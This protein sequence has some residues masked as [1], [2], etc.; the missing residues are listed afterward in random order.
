VSSRPSARYNDPGFLYNQRKLLKYFAIASILM[1]IGVLA[2][3]YVDW[4][5][6]WKRDQLAEMKWEARKLELENMILEARTYQARKEFSQKEAAANEK[7]ESRRD[8]LKEIQKELTELRGAFY[9]ADYDYKAQKQFTGK[10]IYEREHAHADEREKYEQQL[11]AERDKEARLKELVN[12]ANERL[13]DKV[14]EEKSLRVELDAIV[15]EMRQNPELKKMQLVAAAR[16]KKRGYNPLRDVPLLDFLAPPTKVE[17]VVLE[18]LVDN[19]EFALPKKVDRCGTCHVGVMRLGFEAT[20]WPLEALEMEAGQQKSDLLEQ[21]VYE[22]VFTLL[23]SVWPKTPNDSEFKYENDLLRTLA[24]HHETLNMLFVGYDPE[25]GTIPTWEKGPRKGRKIWKR[26]RFSEKSGRWLSGIPKGKTINDYPETGTSLLEYYYGLLQRMEKH[27]RSH[28]FLKDM[29][30]ST[31]PH[32]YEKVGCTVCHNGR[33]WSTDFG[34][35][36]HVPDRNGIDNWMTVARAEEQHLHLPES[37]DLTLDEA[38]LIGAFNAYEQEAWDGGDELKKKLEDAVAAAE[39]AVKAAEG[40]EGANA[41]QAKAAAAKAR[42]DL[43][44]FEANLKSARAKAADLRVGWVTDDEKGHRWHDDLDW[45]H[46]KLHH[47]DWPQLPKMLVQ[48]SCLKCHKEGLYRTAETEYETVHIG[49]PK[50]NV[51]STKSIRPHFKEYNDDPEGDYSGRMFVPKQEEPYRPEALEAGMDAFLRF[52]CYG[53]HKLDPTVYTFMEHQRDKVGPQ[54]NDITSKT[55]KAWTRKWVRNPKDYRPGTRMPRFFGLSNNS[56]DFKYRFADG[57]GNTVEVDAEA[58]NNA[59]IYSIVEWMFAESEKHGTFEAPAVDLSKGDKKRGERILVAFGG[60]EDRAPKACVA[61]HDVPI[62]T[63]E[64]AYKA[65]ELRKW[66]NPATDAKVGWGYRMSRR[67]G[68]DL[69]GLG[70]KLKPEWLVAWLKD[71]RS[72]WHDT[73]MPDLRLTDQE[74][75][76]V[77]A[78]LLSLRHEKF[79]ALE[80]V[81]ADMALV[82][83]IAQELKVGEQ[84]EPTDVALGIV[85]R[86]SDRERVLYVGG[87]LFKN[88]GCFGC[89]SVN[90][91]AT[92]SPI[93]TELTSWGSKLIDRLAFNHVPMEKTRFDFAYTKMMNPRVFDLG[94]AAA[95]SPFERLQMP[96]FNFTSEEAKSIATFLVGLVE[97]PIPE[98]ALF[99]ADARKQQ[100]IDG[101]HLVRRFNCQGCHVIEGEGGDVWPAIAE[102]KWRP[103]DLLGQGIKTN[104]AWLFHFMRDPS[105]VGEVPGIPDSDRVR[106]WHAIRMPTF[107][108]TDDESRTIVRYFAALSKA[109]NDFESVEPDSLVGPGAKFAKS[110]VREIKDLNDPEGKK[111]LRYDVDN[112]LRETEILFAAL[113]CKKCHS[114][115]AELETAAPNFRHTRAGRLRPEWIRTWL[116]NPSKLQPGT[117]MPTFFASEKGPKTDFKAFHGGSP[118]D[119]IR[120]LRDYIR[121]HYD[122]TK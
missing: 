92:T 101:R 121:W 95:E 6:P 11:A 26:Y 119:Q 122:D 1:M 83:R 118:D 109:P 111:K 9:A 62:T 61:C 91:Y 54:L 42:R 46:R 34:F 93:G 7:F 68:P 106:P 97:D 53:C 117:A 45:T 28:P 86:M 99:K 87:T 36:Y 29:V 72:Y 84:R 105:F 40:H 58:W 98:P 78:Y 56:R 33:G 96:R 60:K 51:P 94:T 89:H 80:D 13:N 65:E 2:M 38:M 82:N 116:W 85:K 115:D 3:I 27:W 18:N 81:A 20:K 74:A 57:D 110:E 25:D 19:Y 24:I 43:A 50:A 76:D 112:R 15:D 10:A 17:Q 14:A 100:I 104:P 5:R 66:D 49:K 69:A 73:N 88:Y 102:E 44:D 8:R 75:L 4:A 59:E 37:T 77:A 21:G 120:A 32:P 31:S 48:A 67:Q 114:N 64:L 16:D 52:G 22:F 79:D 35:A 41:T 90:E 70:S 55:D 63:P 47:W 103:P 107:N 39:E 12:L 23:E 108:L 71:P 113:E 30:G